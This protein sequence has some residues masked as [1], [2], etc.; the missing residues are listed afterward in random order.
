MKTNILIPMAGE[1]KRFSE[2]GYAQPKP[3]IPVKIKSYRPDATRPMIQQALECL[4]DDYAQYSPEIILVTQPD[5]VVEDAF[6][7]R[8]AAGP[9]SQIIAHKKTEGPACTALLAKDVVNTDD[10]LIVMN[11]D[12]IILDM[13]LCDLQALSQAYDA[14]VILGCFISTSPKNSYVR[15]NDEGQI[16]EVREKEVIS[17][18]ATN[19]MHWF[20]RGSDFV[21]GAE[22]MIEADD[23]VNGEFYIAPSVNYLI[24]EGL[25]VMPF[26]FIPLICRQSGNA[27]FHPDFK[28][29]T[30]K[31]FAQNR[32]IA[33]GKFP[34]IPF[35]GQREAFGAVRVIVRRSGSEV[36]SEVFFDDLI[37]RLPHV[38]IALKYSGP[39]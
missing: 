28:L 37:Y 15:L 26:F 19:G 21:R 7:K 38:S 24:A 1:G 33:S 34:T 3:L 16:I 27:Y 35:A 25:K 20:R 14:D 17:N 2:A 6:E 31:G 5:F 32:L 8:F 39:N 10:P 22:K 12:Q 9:I 23:R 11:C 30:G 4:W 29:P 36:F 18:I 13:W